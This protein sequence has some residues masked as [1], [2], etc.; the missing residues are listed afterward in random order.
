[1]R[2]P[3]RTQLPPENRFIE[4][5]PRIEIF[6]ANVWRTQFVLCNVNHF[7]WRRWWWIKVA[8]NIG[9]QSL[10]LSLVNGYPG[11]GINVALPSLV[12]R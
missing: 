9:E 1:M 5:I 7:V 4:P 2:S 11:G 6:I 3:P 8:L 10:L 12:L